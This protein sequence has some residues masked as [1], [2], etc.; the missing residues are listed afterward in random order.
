MNMYT[1]G[2]VHNSS[3]SIANATKLLGG[4][5]VSLRP[6]VRSSFCQSICPA[7]CVRSVESTVLVES[8]S[9]VSQNAGILVVLVAHGR[10]FVFIKVLNS[11]TSQFV[12]MHSQ[13]KDSVA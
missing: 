2:S 9:R 11:Q 12:E 4:I 6:S 10:W 8:I 1:D 13:D 7:P 5:L 3:N